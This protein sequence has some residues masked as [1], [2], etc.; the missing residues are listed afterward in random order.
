MKTLTKIL[1][2]ASVLAIGAGGVAYARG[3]MGCG[4]PGMGP[5]FGRAA[6]MER[7]FTRFDA[8]KDGTVTLEEFLAGAGTRFTEIDADKSGVVEK[9]EVETW[10]GRFAP[11]QA[12]AHFLGRH[13]IDGDGKVTKAEFENPLKKRFA[14]FDRNDDGKVNH[15]EL[16]LAGPMGGG[17]R[18][19]W[20]GQQGGGWGGPGQG[21]GAGPGMGG[22]G[23]HRGQGWNRGP[24]W[25]YGPGQGGMQGNGPGMGGPGWGGPQGYGPG[26]GG[27]GMGGMQGNGPGMG[28]PGWGGPQGYGPG[29]GGPGMGGMQGRGPGWGGPQGYG[30]GMGG[31]GMS[32][33]QGYGPGTGGPGMSGPNPQGGAL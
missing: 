20:G 27:P 12:A 23:W 3:P 24:G 8:N 19:G 9:T 11:P 25:Q 31:P 33:P 10:F 5:G 7:M 6:M 29:M 18:G 30:P 22:Q 28:G 15:E 17:M 26:M 16:A 1:I 21:W 14:L 13:D 32:G 2:G 4:G